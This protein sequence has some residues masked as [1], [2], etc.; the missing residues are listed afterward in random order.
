MKSLRN[1]FLMFLI[2]SLTICLVMVSHRAVADVDFIENQNYDKRLPDKVVHG[3][4]MMDSDLRSAKRLITFDSDEILFE[5]QKGHIKEYHFAFGVLWCNDYPIIA[6]IAA[7]HFEFRNAAGHQVSPSRMPQSITTIE[8]TLK[9]VQRDQE[10]FANQSFK[11]PRL[12]DRK[13]ATFAM[14]DSNKD[15]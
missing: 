11:A 8:Y 4:E 15:P 13:E 9:M 1:S 10:L 5:D 2:L 6:E 3:L 12:A 7:F 14:L